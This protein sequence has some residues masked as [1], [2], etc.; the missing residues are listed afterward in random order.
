MT[1]NAYGPT[2]ILRARF[3]DAVFVSQRRKYLFA[4]NEKVANSTMRATFQRLEAGGK[5]PLHYK[6]LKRWTGPLAQPSDLDGFG[7]ILKN[8]SFRKF[9]VVRHPFARLV[10]CYRNKLEDGSRGRG[11]PKMMRQLKLDPKD[12]ITFEKFVKAVSRQ[13]QEDMNPHWRVQYY[14]VFMDMVEYDEVI[15]YEAVGE[16][17]GRLI[18]EFYPK[19]KGAGNAIISE[20]RHAENSD[21]LVARYFTPELKKIAL[22]T[23]Q[24]DFE[25]FGYDV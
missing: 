25:T 15:R 5:L 14:N 20:N 19:A 7:T 1:P 11:F 17:L 10:S 9:C 24:R 13:K 8:P 23:Y 22:A 6:P 3:N 12:E 2:P 21:E 4:S 16:A 18:A